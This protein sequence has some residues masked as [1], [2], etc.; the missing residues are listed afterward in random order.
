MTKTTLLAASLFTAFTCS[1]FAGGLSGPVIEQPVMPIETVEQTTAQPS[2]GSA[3]LP[4]FV[5]T[6]LVALASKN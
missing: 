5:F 6:A 3:L 2:S 4:F 1:A